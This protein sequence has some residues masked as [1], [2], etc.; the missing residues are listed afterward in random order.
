MTS[1]TVAFLSWV[2]IFAQAG[3]AAEG[4]LFPVPKYDGD[5][6]FYRLRSVH[7]EPEHAAVVDARL[8]KIAPVRGLPSTHQ[9]PQTMLPPVRDQ[10][11]R[12]TCAYFATLGLAEA[13]YMA[14][15]PNNKDIELSEECL[16]ELRNWMF[17]DKSYVGDDKPAQRPDPDGDDPGQ[18]ARTITRNGVPL[19]ANY[20]VADCRYSDRNTRALP[21]DVYHQT[22]ATWAKG[23]N[24]DFNAKPTIDSIRA[25]IA[26]NIPV[27]VGVL[28]FNDDFEN[29]TWRYSPWSDNNQTLAGGHAIQL[30]GYRTDSDGQTMFTF[31]NSWGRWGA[32]G[33]GQIQDKRL[34]YGWGYD[35]SLEFTLALH[36]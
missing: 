5:I 25:L 33:Y 30:T 19:A 6:G 36:D 22:P 3:F 2:F 14:Q 7:F 20:P 34:T 18:I 28:V 26:A 31:K 32:H 11:Q 17:D 24:F 27:E 13:Y 4:N 35:S 21:M 29:S 12:G 10:G 1:R 23:A 9:I 16:T 15:S 8:R